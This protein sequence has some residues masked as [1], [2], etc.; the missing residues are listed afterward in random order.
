MY[1][2]IVYFF[3]CKIYVNH[4][5]L[6]IHVIVCPIFV[7]NFCYTSCDELLSTLNPNSSVFKF[8]KYVCALVNAIISV[9]Q[10]GVKSPWM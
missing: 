10:T 6:Y 9:V 1:F 2:F 3:I 7:G 8:L 5:V 4:N